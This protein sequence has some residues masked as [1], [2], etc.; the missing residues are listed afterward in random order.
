MLRSDSIAQDGP[1]LKLKIVLAFV[2]FIAV[3]IPIWLRE[4]SVYR[5][6]LSFDSLNQVFGPVRLILSTEFNPLIC[7]L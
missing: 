5:A 2:I 4:T 6:P 1:L 3:G 7:L